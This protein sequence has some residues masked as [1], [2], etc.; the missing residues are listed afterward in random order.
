MNENDD[1]QVLA[2][3]ASFQAAYNQNVAVFVIFA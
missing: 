2:Q 1:Q 3:K